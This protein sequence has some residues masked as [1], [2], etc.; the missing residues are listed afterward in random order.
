ML[1]SVEG[2]FRNGKVEIAGVPGHVPGETRVIVTFLTPDDAAPGEVDLR[3]HSIDVA[4]AAQL[5]D[6]LARFADEWS[7]PEM[8]AYDDYDAAV[9]GRAAFVAGAYATRHVWDTPEEDAAWA[10]L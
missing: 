8:E 5:R 6:R 10:H 9:A 4:Q 2:V 3:A 7:R 1:T